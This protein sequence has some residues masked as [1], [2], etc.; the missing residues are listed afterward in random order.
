MRYEQYQ[1]SGFNRPEELYSVRDWVRTNHDFDDLPD[2][3][4]MVGRGFTDLWA[5]F[6]DAIKMGRQPV[7]PAS[8]GKRSLEIALGGYLSGVTGRVVTLPLPTDHPVYQHGI[9]GMRDVDVWEHS[10][11]KDMGLYGLRE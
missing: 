2:Y 7:M 3:Q 11:T 10:R 5:D 6:R 1:T 4:D 9:A 8:S